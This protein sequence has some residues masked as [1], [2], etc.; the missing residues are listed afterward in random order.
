M[1]TRLK[2]VRLASVFL[3]LTLALSKTGVTQLVPYD[4]FASKNIDPL[5]WIGWQFFDPDVREA[6]RQPLEEG[7]NL[8]LS[9]TAYS[10]TT[11][12]F[13][14]SGGGFGLGFPDPNAI[15]ETSFT[16]V[17]NRAEAV[18][19]ASNPSLIV[20][21]VEFRGNFFNTESLPTS[22]IGDVQ[23]EIGITRAPTD[24]G[25]AL[26]VAGFY[27]R[28]DDQFCGSQTTFDYRVLGSVQP[29]MSPLCASNGTSQIINSF[30]S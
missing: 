8:R 21:A 6:V 2:S 22:Q 12:D 9:L 11:D 24:V 19:C 10:A 5:K 7:G 23:A 17:V 26:T 1:F 4:D 30:S 18:G 27:S 13:G 14:G 25:G 15:L 3:I 20:T 16:G 29:G 28:C